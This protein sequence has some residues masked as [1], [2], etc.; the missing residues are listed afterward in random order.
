MNLHLLLEVLQQ[1]QMV[2]LI[3]NGHDFIGHKQIGPHKVNV[4]LTFVNSNVIYVLFDVDDN[5]ELDGKKSLGIALQTFDYVINCIYTVN[6]QFANMEYY[7]GADAEHEAIYDKL[8]PR[9]ASRYH[10][11]FQKEPFNM[12]KKEKFTQ[13]INPLFNKKHHVMTA[14]YYIQPKKNVENETQTTT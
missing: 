5:L 10:F 11:T 4:K 8:L 6:Q 7:F 2:P 14:V 9:F 13:A 12:T 1:G 3:K